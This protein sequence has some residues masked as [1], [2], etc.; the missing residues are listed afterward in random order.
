MIANPAIILVDVQN[1]FFTGPLKTKRAPN[2]IEPLQRLVVAARKNAVPV[3]YSIDAHY[4]QDVEV[5]RKWGNHAIKG[6]EGAQVIP[7]LKP[8]EGKDYIVEKRTYSGFYETG[9]DPLLR[10]LYKGD[11]VKTVVLGGLHTNMC[12]RHTSADAFFRGYHIFIA[13][14]GVEAFTAE[15][16][17]QGLKYLEYVYNAKVMMVNEIIE[18][19]V[20]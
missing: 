19:I 1:D 8:E 7:E 4:P 20:K 9:L 5:V 12:I 16:H 15:E 3:I 2:V 14:D 11:G 13:K 6:T 17:E 10:S 18:E